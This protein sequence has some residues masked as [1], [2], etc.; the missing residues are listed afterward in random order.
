MQ[1]DEKTARILQSVEQ[2]GV[3]VEKEVKAHSVTG[4]DMV[5]PHVIILLCLRGTARVMF[6]MQELTIEKND[7]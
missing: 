7:L 3:C 1:I 2:N 6:D 4:V 5:F